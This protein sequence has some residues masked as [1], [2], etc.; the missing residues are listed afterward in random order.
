MQRLTVCG[1]PGCRCQASPPQLHG[2]YWQWSRSVDGKTLTR[3]LTAEQAQL[4]KQWIDNA[5]RLDA[6]IAKMEELS[7]KAAVELTGRPTSGAQS[8]RSRSAR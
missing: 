2:P 1:K 5:R 3:R 6:L 7:E 4:Y 8:R